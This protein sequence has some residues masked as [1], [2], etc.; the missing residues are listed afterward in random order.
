MSYNK[1]YR[2]SGHWSCNINLRLTKKVP[3]IFHDLRGYDGPLIMDEIDKFDVK[4]NVV[5]N[6]L[7]N[8]VAFT[9]NNKKS[10]EFT[11]DLLEIVKQKG[12][13][14][15]DYMDSFEKFSDEKLL[16]KCEFFSFLEDECISKTDYLRA[17]NVWNTFK[18]NAIGDYHDLYL[19]TDVLLLAD[20]F[21]KFVNTCIEYFGFDPW[22]YFS[23]VG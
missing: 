16:N 11:G 17:I 9:I 12:V 13:Y 5:Q 22:H 6:G 4:V 10:E 14:P 2:G 21:V 19:K 1:K 7:E 3:V 8:V 15:Y 18:M 20:V 23:S